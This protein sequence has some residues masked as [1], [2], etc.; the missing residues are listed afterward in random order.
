MA[1]KVEGGHYD[2]FIW[3]CEGASPM[4]RSVRIDD[5]IKS[6]THHITW[7][8]SYLATRAGPEGVDNIGRHLMS[9]V[10]GW[11]GMTGCIHPIIGEKHDVYLCVDGT[12]PMMMITR[13][14][15]A[16]IELGWDRIPWEVYRSIIS[17]AG[18]AVR[19]F[20][21]IRGLL[22]VDYLVEAAFQDRGK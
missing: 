4:A 12:G 17:G 9:S 16:D 1:K 10:G 7:G 2:V 3:D 6:Q 13:H 19:P 8:I 21:R 5:G 15:S 14:G 20:G 18:E 22:P 11:Q